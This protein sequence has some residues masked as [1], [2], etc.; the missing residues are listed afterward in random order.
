M[1][2]QELETRIA[3]N[4]QRVAE[5]QRQLKEDFGP[6]WVGTPQ[7]DDRLAEINGTNRESDRWQRLLDEMTD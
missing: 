3:E 6:G 2:R 5:L 7:W 1:T 4:D